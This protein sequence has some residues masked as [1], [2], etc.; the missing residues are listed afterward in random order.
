MDATNSISRRQ[1]VAAS[2]LLLAGALEGV[3]AESPA[4]PGTGAKLAIEGGEKTIATPAIHTGRWGEPELQTTRR[5]DPPRFALL[6]EH[7]RPRRAESENRIAH[8]AVSENLS[9]RSTCRPAPRALPRSTSQPRPAASGP[10][11]K[12]SARPIPIPARSSARSTSRACRCSPTS[13]PAPTTS[14]RPTW[15]EKSP[16][17]TKAIVAVH[18]MGNPCDVAAL[19]AIG[20]QAQAGTD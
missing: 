9:I 19:K 11:T 13:C 15:S 5:N 8:R 4:A 3:A 10:A 1:F 14:I 2:S 16:S 18:L 7:Q 12:S 20:R 17:K 6:L